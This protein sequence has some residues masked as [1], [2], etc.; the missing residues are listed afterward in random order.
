MGNSCDVVVRR[1]APRWLCSSP[2]H[3][4]TWLLRLLVCL[5]LPIAFQNLKGVLIFDED[6]RLQSLTGPDTVVPSIFQ[7]SNSPKVFHNEHVNRTSGSL[8]IATGRKERTTSFYLSTDKF[9][10]RNESW[11]LKSD[12]NVTNSSIT[13]STDRVGSSTFDQKASLKVTRNHE[14]PSTTAPLKLVHVTCP[15]AVV[16]STNGNASNA[17]LHDNPFF[18]LDQTQNVTIASMIRARDSARSS[19]RVSIFGGVFP[20]DAYILPDRLGIHKFYLNRSTETTYPHIKPSKKLPFVA[21]VFRYVYDLVPDCDYIIY[22]NIDI[23]L[24]DSFYNRVAEIIK[25]NGLAAFTIN[26]RSIP[27]DSPAKLD[28]GDMTALLTER[29]LDAIYA[30]I[31]NGAF[32][33]GKDCFVIRR[34]LIPRLNFG[35]LFLG[36]PPWGKALDHMIKNIVN[37]SEHHNYKSDVNLTFHLGHDLNWHEDNAQKSIMIDKKRRD[38]IRAC[39]PIQWKL[40][41][42]RFMTPYRLQN[43]KNCAELFA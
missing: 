5:V 4:K 27:R 19:I 16:P 38:E 28:Q 26:R 24:H 37:K 14:K 30:L 23:G 31:P 17:S 20:E 33:P 25:T 1:M 21:D 3:K 9:S 8:M 7:L 40:K 39:P 34:E 18:P 29:D 13:G 35:S 43:T 32:H 12:S 2:I 15:Y 6:A 10:S 36:F 22:T 41:D 11:K 42:I